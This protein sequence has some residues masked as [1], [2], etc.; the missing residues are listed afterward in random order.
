MAV[1]RRG[2]R[3][4]THDKSLC[5]TVTVSPMEPTPA[6]PRDDGGGGGG[7]EKRNKL[8]QIQTQRKEI[9][10]QI[11]SNN[12]Q[13]LLRVR[14]SRT[15]LTC[16]NT[17]ANSKSRIKILAPPGGGYD[18]YRVISPYD[19]LHMKA[20][21]T[22]EDSPMPKKQ[23]HTRLVRFTPP[24]YSPHEH[25]RVSTSPGHDS[26]A[27]SPHKH[28]HAVSHSQRSPTARRHPKP[29]LKI[30]KTCCAFQPESHGQIKYIRLEQRSRSYGW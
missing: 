8:N 4:R 3:R 24:S 9:I 27:A 14:E 22:A 12:S 10:E 23:Q 6:V 28:Q 5:V 13:D 18:D 19:R 2:P 1:R 25:K 7:D 17:Y 29:I 15:A 30:P 21:M 11:F 20:A 16:H 26:D